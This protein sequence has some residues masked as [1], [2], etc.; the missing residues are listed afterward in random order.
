MGWERPP[1]TLQECEK[2]TDFT[3][4]ATIKCLYKTA[5]IPRGVRKIVVTNVRDAWPADPEGQIVGRRVAQLRV[6]ARTF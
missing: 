1:F 6:E 4:P 5:R 2:L 3:L